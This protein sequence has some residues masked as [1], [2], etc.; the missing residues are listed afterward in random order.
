[1]AKQ[2][3]TT[4]HLLEKPKEDFDNPALRIDQSNLKLTGLLDRAQTSNGRVE[5]IQ[6]DEHAVLIVVQVSLVSFVSLALIVVLGLAG[7]GIYRSSLPPSAEEL[8]TKIE[9]GADQPHRAGRYPL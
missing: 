2:V 7:F 6:Q 5:Q 3:R 9:L 1:M 8:F 4:Q